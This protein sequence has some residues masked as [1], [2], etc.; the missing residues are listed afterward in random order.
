V[1]D[2]YV[3]KVAD[4]VDPIE[5]AD[6]MLATAGLIVELQ[7]GTQASKLTLLAALNRM[8]QQERRHHR[9]AMLCIDD[10]AHF[11]TTRVAR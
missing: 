5:A 11:G 10:T 9:R 8:S 1:S 3:A 6:A 7:R 4:G 2:T